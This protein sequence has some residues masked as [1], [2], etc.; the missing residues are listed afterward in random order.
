[1]FGQPYEFP[2]AMNPLKADVYRH[3]LFITNR[4]EIYMKG[5]AT[6][7]DCHKI[8][9]SDVINIWENYFFPHIGFNGVYLKVERLVQLALN[10]NKIPITRRND[11][12]YEKFKTSNAMFDICTCNC[13]EKKISRKDCRCKDKIPM[14]GWESFIGQK[15]TMKSTWTN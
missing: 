14:M 15:R 8:V 5:S 7:K 10:V 9:A 3:Y 6:A 11:E 12:L 4:E 2:T 13:Y 1:M